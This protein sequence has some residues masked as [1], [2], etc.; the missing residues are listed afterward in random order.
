MIPHQT[1]KHKPPRPRTN[2]AKT[3]KPSPPRRQQP[4]PSPCPHPLI[5]VYPLPPSPRCAA[6]INAS[7]AASGSPPPPPNF[8][9]SH[10]PRIGGQGGSLPVSLS[11]PLPPRVRDHQ[12][13]HPLRR[14]HHAGR[15]D[16]LVRGDHQEPLGPRRHRGLDHVAHAQHVH[17]DCAQYRVGECLD[18]VA[19]HQRHVLVRAR[20][21]HTLRPIRLE[22]GPDA[23]GEADVGDDGDDCR[24]Q[25]ADCRFADSPIRR[26]ADSPIRR[27]ADSLIR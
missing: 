16:R 9:G 20:V 19:L 17:F 1:A 26:F 8:G 10:L 27:F 12:L 18:L 15:V 22:H 6:A 7:T 23:V 25:I 13:R 21:K 11:P 24:L 2:P 3:T 5:R 4:R 14:A